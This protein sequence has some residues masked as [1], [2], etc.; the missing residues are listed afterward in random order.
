MARC[1]VCRV[2]IEPKSGRGRPPL[3]CGQVCKRQARYELRRVQQRLYNLES[4][5]E[6]CRRPDYSTLRFISGRTAAERLVDIEVEIARANRRLR[7][8]LAAA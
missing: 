4:E 3:Y 6:V 1:L 5:R 7:E 2:K 8:L